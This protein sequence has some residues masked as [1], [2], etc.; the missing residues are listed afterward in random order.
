MR[1]ICSIL[2]CIFFIKEGQNRSIF[3]F[4][5]PQ[6][7]RQGDGLLDST[8]TL[9]HTLASPNPCKYSKIKAYTAQ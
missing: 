9:G 8:P 6:S 3:L 5:T 1:F 7:L 4:Q 2:M